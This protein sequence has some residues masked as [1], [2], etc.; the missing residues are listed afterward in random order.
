MHTART[1]SFVAAAAVA[2]LASGGCKFAPLP[3]IEEDAAVDHAVGG[4]VEGLWTGAALVLRLDVSGREPQR[5]TVDREGAFAFPDRLLS[6]TAFALALESDADQH[7]CTVETPTGEVGAL[8]VTNLRVRCT[9]QVVVS[10]ALS[11]LQPFTFDPQV[12]RHEL[13]ASVLLGQL[14]VTVGGPV[15][16]T[17]TL[18][19]APVSLA[20]P[21]TPAVLA[22]GENT[23][24]IDVTVG[25]LSRRYELVVNRGAV[26]P[27]E[28]FYA[29]AAHRDADDFFGTSVATA[30]DLVAVAAP[31]EDSASGNNPADNSVA[32]SGAVLVY[33]RR[34]SEVFYLKSGSTP[35]SG[36]RLGTS[37]AMTDEWVVAGAADGT[38]VRPGAV[39]IWRRSGSFTVTSERKLASNATDGD[40]YGTS[41]DVFG[42]TMAVAA[43]IGPDDKGAVYIYRRSGWSWV[44]EAILRA[45][46]DTEN[47]FFGHA[48]TLGQDVIA[49]GAPGE[50][51]A[52]TGVSS[53]AA[54][55]QAARSGAVYIFRRTGTTWS[56]EAYVK[57]SNTGPDDNFGMV[58]DLDGDTLAVAAPVEGSAGADQQDNSLSAAGAVYVFRHTAGTWAQEAYVKAPSP[59]SW[60][61]FGASISLRGDTLAVGAPEFIDRNDTGSVHLFN[62]VGTT[63]GPVARLRAS[64]ADPGDKFSTVALGPDGLYVG[65]QCESAGAT[66]AD[67]NLRFAGAAYFFR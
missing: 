49:I 27:Q 33:Q 37:L 60:D 39:H 47:A 45:P 54:T 17:A 30:G 50:R 3:D 61:E 12:S 11:T 66:P 13:D 28:Y 63:W 53:M 1:V 56:F 46:N 38:G 64:N 18:N 42:D 25:A 10:V 16:T 7:D 4:T 48:I 9:S 26:Q 58:L 34:G 2:A 51:S 23:L 31:Y 5:L 55:D 65:A 35:T 6:D 52:A 8:D 20:V 15:G 14:A 41:I 32:E 67:N 44:E 29:K 24:A 43:S 19:G 62:R 40:L 22:M 57:A 21:S 36:E 59:A